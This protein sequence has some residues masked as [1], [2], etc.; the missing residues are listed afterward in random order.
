MAKVSAEFA[1]GREYRPQGKQIT[2]MP[3]EFKEW[4]KGNKAHIEDL[5]QRG[6]EPYF[7]R[8]NKDF[9]YGNQNKIQGLSDGN[10]SPK[11][12]TKNP[13]PDEAKARRKQIKNEA[14]ASILNTLMSAPNFISPLT[15][16]Y[17]G[18]KEWLNQ[19]FRD[20]EMKNEA[21]LRLPDLMKNSKYM[22]YTVD[23]HDPDVTAHIFETDINGLCW[24]IVREFKN[25]LFLIHS[26][27]DSERI[28]KNLKKKP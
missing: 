28:L 17:R 2:A 13:L 11:R 19:P 27:T 21:L 18:I 14:R 5:R 22:G 24:V 9:V 7:V 10:K 20:M 15:I 23:K 25:G 16:S 8:D 12:G 6:K 3:S 1:E 26:V 4:V